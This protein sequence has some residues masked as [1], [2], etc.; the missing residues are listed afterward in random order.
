M[1]RFLLAAIFCLGVAVPA[2]AWDEGIDTGD[3]RCIGTEPFWSL[4]LGEAEMAYDDIEGNEIVFASP[5]AETT[6]NRIDRWIRTGISRSGGVATIVLLRQECSDGMS[7]NVFPLE[8][9]V[10]GTGPRTLQGC[11]GE[12]RE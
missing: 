9:I 2:A 12:P 7:D 5:P 10:M 3:L 11:C 1:T 4:A 8:V 6:A